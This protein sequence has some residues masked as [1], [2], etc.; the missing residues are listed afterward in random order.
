MFM[1]TKVRSRG[2]RNQ[3]FPSNL[4]YKY[5]RNKDKFWESD[6]MYKGEVEY[7]FCTSILDRHFKLLSFINI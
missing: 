2:Q 7:H 6:S 4:N 1:S 5:D 3:R